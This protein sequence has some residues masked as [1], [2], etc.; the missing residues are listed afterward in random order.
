MLQN[1][2]TFKHSFL[3]NKV[4]KKLIESTRAYK[5]H[6]LLN[7]IMTKEYSK[8]GKSTQKVLSSYF[9]TNPPTFK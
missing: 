6:F 5:G 8:H 7:V 3:E 2:K 4:K 1:R 9:N